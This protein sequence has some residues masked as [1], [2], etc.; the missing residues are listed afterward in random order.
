MEGAIFGIFSFLALIIMIIGLIN[1]KI[2]KFHSRKKVFYIFG[3]IFLVFFIIGVSI[4]P[5]TTNSQS[6]Q[7][8]DNKETMK[9]KVSS[10][11]KILAVKNLNSFKWEECVITLNDIYTVK[12]NSLT[13]SG[14]DNDDISTA[15]II[16]LDLFTK[17]DGS[18][19]NPNTQKPLS[20]SVGCK[21][22]YI[23]AFGVNFN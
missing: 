19:F 10:N 18:L 21:K 13:V 22:P 8:A 12:E 5:P 23:D 15:N 3:V 14:D 7:T 2:I 20:I 11:G 17:S 9:L 16:S 4:T 6:Q 1:P